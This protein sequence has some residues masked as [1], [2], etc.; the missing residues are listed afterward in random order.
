MQYSQRQQKN[1]E[2]VEETE[3]L[4]AQLLTES[5]YTSIQLKEKVLD[6]DDD[7]DDDDDGDDDGDGNNDNDD[8]D[9]DC[10]EEIFSD[11]IASIPEKVQAHVKQLHLQQ[12]SELLQIQQLFD[13]SHV[14]YGF[15]SESVL[16]TTSI[17][18]PIALSCADTWQSKSVLSHIHNNIDYKFDNFLSKGPNLALGL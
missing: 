13:F 4:I 9:N 7:D 6:D 2:L 10:G 18:C 15:D 11:T 8:N 1:K 12:T 3:E 5:Q 16:E 14:M 17:I